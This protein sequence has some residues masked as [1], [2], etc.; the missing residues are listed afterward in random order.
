MKELHL[1]CSPL[2]VG[3]ADLSPMP[4]LCVSISGL[5]RLLPCMDAC[6]NKQSYV[7]LSGLPRP[8]H[9]HPPYSARAGEDLG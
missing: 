1:H 4:A 3:G 2:M 8:G 9:R 5:A 6:T 7:V